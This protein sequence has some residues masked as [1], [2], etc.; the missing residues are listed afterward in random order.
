MIRSFKHR[1]LERFFGKGTTA[2]INAQQAQ[3]IRLILG[4]LNASIS[5]GDMKLPGLFLHELTG[6]RKGTWTVRVSANW[7]ITF[8]FDGPHACDVN[9]EDY[10]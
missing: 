9:Y 2:G 3:R 5:P 4:R 7:R 6:K 1:G 10:H 8:R